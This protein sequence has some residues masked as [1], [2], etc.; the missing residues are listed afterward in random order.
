MKVKLL[1]RSDG[2]GYLFRVALAGN[3]RE[4]DQLN[5]SF[6]DELK[7]EDDIVLAK[8]RT[9]LLTLPVPNLAQGSSNV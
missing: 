6:S 9:Q 2:R 8:E 1:Q 4:T 5:N 3:T 7:E